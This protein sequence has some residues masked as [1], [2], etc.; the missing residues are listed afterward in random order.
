MSSEDF[1][2]LLPHLLLTAGALVVMIVVAF[3]RVHRPVYV[4]TCLTFVVAL[5]F[6]INYDAYPHRVGTLFVV[7][8]FGIFNMALILLAALAVMLMSYAYFEHREERT[9]EYYIVIIL[10][11]LGACIL[12]ISGHFISLFLELEI[13]SVSLYGMISYLRKRE[14]SDE[15]GIKYLILAAFSSA[16]PV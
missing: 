3:R 8:G 7:D 12:V 10:V 11:T 14:R 15:A 16:F 1:M 2:S 13:L 9:G 4:L 6:L 5:Y